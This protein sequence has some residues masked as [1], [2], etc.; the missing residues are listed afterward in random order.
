MKMKKLCKFCLG[1]NQE[2]AYI[3]GS[4][5]GKNLLEKRTFERWQEKTH[6]RK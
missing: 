1:S 6:K 2:S 3:Y 4:E 5:L